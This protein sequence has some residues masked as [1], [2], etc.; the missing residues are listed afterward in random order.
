MSSGKT[1][2]GVVVAVAG[3]VPVA[4]SGTDVP[5]VVDPGT[6]AQNTVVAY[7]VVTLHT[8]NGGNLKKCRFLHSRESV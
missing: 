7:T 8:S 6:P 3:V 4:V 1:K 5:A 2:T